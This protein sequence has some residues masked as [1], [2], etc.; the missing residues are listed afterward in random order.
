M[1]P[2]LTAKQKAASDAEVEN[3]VFE[4]VE[5]V[6]KWTQERRRQEALEAVTKNIMEMVIDVPEDKKIS[7]DSEEEY[8]ESGDDE[9]ISYNDLAASR[10]LSPSRPPSTLST[11]Q[12]VARPAVSQHNTNQADLLL[13]PTVSSTGTHQAHAQPLQ[14]A[15]APQQPPIIITEAD[16]QAGRAA[17]PVSTP[18]FVHTSEGQ[19][20]M[21]D[22]QVHWNGRNRA[23]CLKVGCNDNRGIGYSTPKG[24]NEHLRKAHPA[25]NQPNAGDQNGQLYLVLQ[26]GK[27]NV[28]GMKMHMMRYWVVQ[29]MI[30]RR[31][32]GGR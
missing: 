2:R 6:I 4:I 7:Q 27:R 16:A 29:A 13:Q 25:F 14:P 19:Y 24:R 20:T 18:V 22:G 5:S 12:P 31:Q 9:E 17:Y 8:M 11:Q 1:P 26:V 3:L 32:R 21:T 30:S 23:Q 10:P 15:I 28:A